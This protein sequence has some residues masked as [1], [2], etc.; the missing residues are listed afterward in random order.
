MWPWHH[1]EES[2]GE[3]VHSSYPEGGVSLQPL[4]LSVLAYFLGHCSPRHPSSV[5]W[6]WQPVRRWRRMVRTVWGLESEDLRLSLRYSFN[7]EVWLLGLTHLFNALFWG[8]KE[9]PMYEKCFMNPKVLCRI[10]AYS[11]PALH[12]HWFLLQSAECT[13]TS[14]YLKGCIAWRGYGLQDPWEGQVTRFG[15]LARRDTQTAISPTTWLLGF[16]GWSRVPM[17]GAPWTLLSPAPLWRA[18]SSELAH[19]HLQVPG[20][21]SAWKKPGCDE[22]LVETES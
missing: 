3:D 2:L 4:H 18:A 15:H 5:L 8:S 12:P 11:T 19:F 13:L 22:T 9:H 16:Q 14:S 1:Q 7:W 20:E 6:V 17:T 10:K 21:W